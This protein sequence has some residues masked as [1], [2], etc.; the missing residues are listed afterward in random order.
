MNLFRQKQPAVLLLS[1]MLSCAAANAMAAPTEC[2][3]GQVS[4]T[5]E[6]VY[7]TAGQPVPCEV[8]Y[9]KPAQGTLESLWRA[10]NQAGYCE[11]QAAAFITMLESMGW[12]CEQSDNEQEPEQAQPAS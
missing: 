3:L 10:R 12:S 9:A 7:A 6:V 8:L 5:V 1:A 11:E 4:R 2:H